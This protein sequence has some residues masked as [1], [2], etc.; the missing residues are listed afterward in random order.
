M[1][2][3][4]KESLICERNI[5]PKI[6]LHLEDGFTQADFTIEFNIKNPDLSGVP[7]DIYSYEFESGQF[8]N[9]YAERLF[10]EIK[11]SIKNTNNFSI[12]DWSFAGRSNGWFILICTGDDNNIPENKLYKIQNIVENYFNNYNKEIKK[13]YKIK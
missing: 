13:Y 5:E 10:N 9:K 7:D 3:L 4:V 2:K 1:K 12:D 6:D 11:S 8:T